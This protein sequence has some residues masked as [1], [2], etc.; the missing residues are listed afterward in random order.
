MLPSLIVLVFFLISDLIFLSVN[1]SFTFGIIVHIIVQ[2]IIANSPFLWKNIEDKI[3]RIAN[4][5]E[6]D[7]KL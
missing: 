3:D 1:G 6:F 5:R 2:K 7:R 4:L